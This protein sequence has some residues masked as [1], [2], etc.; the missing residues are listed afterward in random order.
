VR[1]TGSELIRIIKVMNCA[2]D[3]Y[4]AKYRMWIS[5]PP[6]FSSPVPM[7]LPRFGCKRFSSYEELNTWKYQYR[8]EIARAGGLQWKN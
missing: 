8:M 6:V 5:N 2:K 4:K 1:L 3:D 7:N